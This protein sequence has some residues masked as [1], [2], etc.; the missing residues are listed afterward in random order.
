MSSSLLSTSAGQFPY[1]LAC[2]LRSTLPRNTA[3]RFIK[4]VTSAG[5]CVLLDDDDANTRVQRLP[6]PLQVP[7]QLLVGQVAHAPLHPD[8]IVADA[9]L[10]LPFFQPEREGV[11]HPGLGLQRDG[12][13]GYRLDDVHVVGQVEKQTFGDSADTAR[14]KRALLVTQM[15]PRHLSQFDKIDIP[16]PALESVDHFP[17]A[18]PPPDAELGE[19]AARALEIDLRDA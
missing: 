13:L 1:H 6:A 4:E 9:V 16:C 12:E 5:A 3:V 14:V 18:I 2:T 7:D 15:V 10:G 8:E 17:L 19:E 11:A